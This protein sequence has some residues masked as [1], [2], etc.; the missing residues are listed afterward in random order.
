MILTVTLNPMLDKTVAVESFTRGRIHRA[1]SVGTVVGGKGVNVSRQLH[2]LDV[3]TLASGCWGGPI[4][5][6]LKDLLSAEGVPNDFL[7]IGS[8]TREGVTYREPDGTWTAVFEPPHAVTPQEADALVHKCRGLIPRAGWIVC[9]GSS[10]CPETDEVYA[11]IIA[12]AREA[13]IQTALDS[14]GRA[15]TLGLAA[16]PTMV[17]VNAQEYCQTLHRTLGTDE[18]FRAALV[19]FVTTGIRY[20]IIT[21]GSRPFFAT[22]GTEWWKVI[23]S[24]APSVNPTGS[25]DSMIAGILAALES[26]GSF[27]RALVRGAAAGGA[28]ARVWEVSCATAAEISALEPGVHLEHRGRLQ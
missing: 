22:D 5:R 3:P 11:R 28:N 24:P 21:D 16:V 27:A 13:G 6:V 14:Y 15:F 18:E 9:C 25:G 2:R 8:T 19:W 10:P 1:T 20:A 17:K 12:A 26:G 7:E 23:P 4:G